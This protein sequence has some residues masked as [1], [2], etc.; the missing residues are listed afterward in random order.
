GTNGVYGIDGTFGFFDNLNVNTY[1]ARSRTD[2][3]RGKDTSFRGQIDYPGERLGVPLEDLG[4]GDNFNPEAGFVR[5]DDI[6]RSFGQFRFSPRPTSIKAV[7]RFSWL[8]SMA[9]IAN[10]AGRLETRESIGEFAVEFQN[11]DRLSLSL[12]DTYEFL[13]RLFAI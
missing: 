1:W 4:V 2:G 12:T 11:S 10:G 7:R 3:R 9:Y 8:G 6:R 5:R 13:P